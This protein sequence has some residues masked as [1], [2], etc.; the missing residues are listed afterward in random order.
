MANEVISSAT[1]AEIKRKAEA[2]IALDAPTAGKQEAYDRYQ[3]RITQLT[4]ENALRGDTLH[5]PND[6]KN[7]IWQDARMNATEKDPVYFENSLIMDRNQAKDKEQLSALERMMQQWG[8]SSMK[9]QQ[10]IL[11]QTRDAQLA[12]IKKALEDAVTEGQIS[13]R[14]AEAQFEANKK[15]IDQQAYQ[16]AERTNAMSQDRGIQNS[17]QS[18]G[19][20]QGDNAR[21]NSMVNEN[22]TTRDKRVADIKDRL[23]AIKNKSDIDSITANATHGYGSAAAQGNIDSQ[24]MQQMFQLYQQNMQQDK[25][26][27]FQLDLGGKQNQWQNQQMDKQ[28]KYTLEQFATQFGYDLK[29]MDKQQQQQLEQMAKQFGYNIQTMDKQQALTLEQFAVQHGYDLQKMDAQ[30]RNQLEQMATNQGYTITNMGI[31]HEQGKEILGLNQSFQAS[32]AQLDRNQQYGI[33]AEQAKN[34]QAQYDH[35]MQSVI[36][37]EL[38]KYEKGTDQYKIREGQLNDAYNAQQVTNAQKIAAE[39]FAKQEVPK[40][41]GAKPTFVAN[42][43]PVIVP[44]AIHDK[45]EANRKKAFNAQLEQWNLL[46]KTYKDYQ[47]QLKTYTGTP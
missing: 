47:T 16:D 12:E 29:K 26:N 32:Q 46:D 31:A 11:D 35:E 18:I 37:N 4:K 34:S 41:P 14:E 6:F 5:E 27:Q 24:M 42:K 10:A 8:E 20:M 7:K 45:L 3:Q 2:G 25:N 33:L 15:Q 44:K 9:S 22:M 17:A 38:A 28:Q 13:T 43:K 40:P 39:A 21:R 19:L 36:S 30:Q 1:D 23:N